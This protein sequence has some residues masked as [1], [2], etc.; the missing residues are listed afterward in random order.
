MK[1]YIGRWRKAPLIVYFDSKVNFTSGEGAPNTDYV[2][3]GMGLTVSVDLVEKGE[4]LVQ[5][6]LK[7]PAT[8]RNTKIELSVLSMAANLITIVAT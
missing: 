8:T 6:T 5:L 2:G 3:Q 4:V 1:M 7:K